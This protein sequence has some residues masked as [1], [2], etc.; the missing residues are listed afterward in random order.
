ME[1]SHVIFGPKINHE[2]VYWGLKSGF[3]VPFLM[4][5][6]INVISMFTCHLIKIIKAKS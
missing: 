3:I 2:Q 6:K 5:N 4:I 1:W